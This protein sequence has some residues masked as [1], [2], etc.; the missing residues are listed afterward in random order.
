LKGKERKGK[1][2]ACDLNLLYALNEVDDGD[3]PVRVVVEMV[4]TALSTAVVG[5]PMTWTCSWSAWNVLI[6]S[7]RVSK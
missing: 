7:K 5:K 4:L 3:L 1:S 2:I 6:L